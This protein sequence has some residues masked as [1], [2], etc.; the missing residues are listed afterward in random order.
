MTV[1]LFSII[2]ADKRG[3]ESNG[4]LCAPSEIGVLDETD[5]ILILNPLLANKLG[6]NITELLYLKK[7]KVLT[8]ASR[9][10]RG[11]AVCVRGIAREISALFERPLRQP[12]WQLPTN[13]D[14]KHSFFFYQHRRS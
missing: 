3:V 11:D 7:D 12:S 6:V 5:G 4:M 8:V 10:N 9:S 14:K 2:K 13:I 1:V